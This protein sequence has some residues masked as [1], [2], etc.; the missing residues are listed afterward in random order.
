MRKFVKTLWFRIF[1]IILAVLVALTVIAGVIG[2]RSSPLTVAAGTVSS[3][4]K[5]VFSYV[6]RGFQQ[7]GHFFV[8]PSEYEKRIK[9]LENRVL[10]Y[11]KELADYEATKEKLK[12]YEEFLSIKEEHPDYK[13][14][15]A[16]VIGR[17]AA[18]GNS[19]FVFNKGSKDG[20]KV[21]DPVIYGNGQLV[22][23]V[24][25]TAPTYCVAS[26]ILD[27]KL[28]VSAY[29]IRSRETGYLSNT[30]ELSEKGYCKMSGLERQTAVS[31]G[32]VI[33]TAGVGGIYPRDLIIGTVEKVENDKHDISA[34]AVIKPNV[35]LDE[36]NEVLIITEF[37][38]QGISATN[39]G[40]EKE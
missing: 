10:T 4:V 12:T 40:E 25:K 32:G 35:R 11:Q 27:T 7:I 5:Q 17:D 1:S 33:C 13:A 39:I 23:V 6:G 9:D 24:T 34:Y 15:S 16:T 26:T 22:G 30:P 3:P 21:N 38:G 19:T 29:D 20:I 31:K 36:I 37:S 28:S 14:V 18:G 8:R 2:S